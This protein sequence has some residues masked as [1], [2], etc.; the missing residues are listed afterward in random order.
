MNGQLNVTRNLSYAMGLAILL[1]LSL[2]AKIKCKKKPSRE[3]MGHSP[4]HLN[5]YD[6]LQGSLPNHLIENHTVLPP[7]LF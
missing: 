3:L 2:L 1:L 7:T 4:T 6:A 5:S